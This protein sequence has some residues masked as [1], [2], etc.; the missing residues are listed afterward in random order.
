MN[1][2]KLISRRA[3]CKSLISILVAPKLHAM[4][5]QPFQIAQRRKQFIQK[6]G[7]DILVLYY[8]L[9]NN[10]EIMAKAI[11]SRYEADLIEIAVKEYSNDFMGRNR[12]S[13]DAWT[14]KR[15]STI[16]PGTIDLN[17]YRF[18][19][20]G[21]PIWWFRPAVPL[22]TFVEKN[23]FQ[24]QNIILFN[25]FNSRFKDKHIYEF[26]DLV[27]SKGG[28]LSDHIFIR[29]GRWYN[30]LDQKELVEQIQSLIK[31][32]ERKWDFRPRAR[33]KST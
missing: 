10:T 20:L 8:S 16:D 27:K 7:N 31:S 14:E 9:T 5:I 2:I 32:K 6:K 15:N 33:S 13:M 1:N 18:I 12:A 19:F 30:Q 24:S 4:Q 11:A 22:W 17:H 28:D 3:F 21:S 26:S 25:T 23:N 29:R